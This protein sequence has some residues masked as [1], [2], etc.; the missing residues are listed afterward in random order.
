MRSEGLDRFRR[1]GVRFAAIAGWGC[2]LWL[3]IMGWLLDHPQLVRV[4]AVG[5]AVNVLPTLAAWRGR[6]D[7]GARLAAGTLAAVHPALGVYL[8]GGHAW[9]IDGHMYFFVALAALAV[10]CDWRPILLAA[11]LT[12]THHL[13]LRFTASDWVFTGESDIGRVLIHAVAVV[14]Q[15]GALMF[16][17]TRLR[18]LMVEQGRSQAESE[19]LARIATERAAELEVAVA[20]AE[21][22]VA[23]ADQAERNER[24]ERERREELERTTAERRRRDM[25]ALAAEFEGSVCGLAAKVADAVDKVGSAARV[26][27]SSTR[28]T[29]S[30]AANVVAIADQSSLGAEDLASRLAELSRS[31]GA[32]AASLEAQGRSSNEAAQRSAGARKVMEDLHARTSRIADFAATIDELARKTNL[33]ALNATIEATRAGDAGR[34]FAVVAGE[35]KGLA[36]QAQQATSSIQD[37]ARLARDGAERTQGALFEIAS[38]VEQLAGAAAS[39]QEELDRQNRTTSSIK[40]AAADSATG[41]S[42]IVFEMRSIAGAAEEAAGFSN[43]VSAAV[44][45]LSGVASLLKEQAGRFTEQLRAA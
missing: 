10:L 21:Q 3:A 40:D 25:L 38:L 22:A 17:T 23:A 12:A 9:Q 31:V 26:L 42:A 32:V 5:A 2:V 8:L 29:T 20:R 15:A 24:A 37:L 35:V 41:A 44:A 14:L 7:P 13:V 1:Q 33:L 34:G 43:E 27:G 45:D 4:V 11:A 19:E 39:I 36:G 16:V 30:A 28:R 6:F 18:D